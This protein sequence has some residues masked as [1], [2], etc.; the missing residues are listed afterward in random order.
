MSDVGKQIEALDKL[1]ELVKQRDSLNE[2][3]A[4]VNS[5]IADM[6][7]VVN[8]NEGAIRIKSTSNKRNSDIQKYIT[9]V[10]AYGAYM[11]VPQLLVKLKE[12]GYLSIKPSTLRQALLKRRDIKRVSRG[13]Y[14]RVAKLTQVGVDNNE[15]KDKENNNG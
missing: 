15:Q 10:M 11:T 3:L 8:R 12:E 9:K 2:H 6:L 7:Q 1:K 5:K 13:T 14:T 4:I